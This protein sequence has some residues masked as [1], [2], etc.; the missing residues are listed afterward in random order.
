MVLEVEGVQRLR[1]SRGGGTGKSLKAAFFTFL[2]ILPPIGSLL[3]S[4]AN[5]NRFSPVTI[6]GDDS[7][8]SSVMKNK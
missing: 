4:L 3:T 5:K 6:N 1:G 7:V 8:V 2:T